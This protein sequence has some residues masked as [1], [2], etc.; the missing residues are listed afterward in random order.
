MILELTVDHPQAVSGAADRRAT[1]HAELKRWM[2]G[3][4]TSNNIWRKTADG[5]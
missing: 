3:D 2:G 5:R 4:H 1:A